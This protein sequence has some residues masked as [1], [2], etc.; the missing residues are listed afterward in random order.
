MADKVGS[1]VVDA[2]GNEAMNDADEAMAE[3][4]G[5]KK[6]KTKKKKSDASDMSDG[7]DTK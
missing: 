3:R 2:A 1:Y 5:L 6:D 7:S 4:H